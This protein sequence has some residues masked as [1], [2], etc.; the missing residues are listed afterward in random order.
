MVSFNKSEN[1]LSISY[2][3]RAIVINYPIR[4]NKYFNYMGFYSFNRRA[5][6]LLYDKQGYEVKKM[7]L[8]QDLI[9]KYKHSDTE[10]VEEIPDDVTRD[11]YLRSLRRQ[12]RVLDEEEE[13]EHLKKKIAARQKDRMRTHLYGIKDKIEKKQQLIKA[14]NK[15]KEVNILREK[16]PLLRKKKIQERVNSESWLGKHNL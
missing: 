10:E 2:I 13:K 11:K 15:K 16:L 8:I 12:D 1:A 6:V 14:L 3:V 4:K 9:E 5:Y 7:G